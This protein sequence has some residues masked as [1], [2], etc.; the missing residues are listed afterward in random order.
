MYILSIHNGHN[1]TAA[2]AKDGQIIACVS[3]ERVVNQ[4]NFLGFPAK[5]IAKVLAMAG[6]TAQELDLVC[7]PSRYGAP[8]HSSSGTKKDLGVALF[9]WLYQPINVVR[10]VWGQL[11]YLIPSFS[12]IG[13]FFYH[14]LAKTVGVYT[15]YRERMFVA[16][17]LG[18]APDKIINF[19]HHQ[20]HA[21][22]AYLASPYNREKALVF[23]LD[24]E[25]DLLCAT[26]SIADKGQLTRIAATFRE[27]SFGWVFYYLT[28]YLG[29]KPMEHEYKVMGLA[30][31]AKEKDVEPLY[32][33]IEQ[34]ITLDQKNPLEFCSLFNTQDTYRYLKKEME[35]YRFDNIAA[36]F[37]KLL[38]E[39]LCEWVSFGIRKTGIDTV[40]VSGGVFMN[41]KANQRVAALPG[42][43]RFYVLPTCGD[44]SLPI[45]ACLTGYQLACS[46]ASQSCDIEPIKDIYWGP[47]WTSK[48]IAAFL[49][50]GNYARKYSVTRLDNMEERVAQLLAEGKVVGRMAGRMEW[51]A[52]ALGNRS[53]LADPSNSDVVMILNEQMK[54]RDFWMPFAPSI[55]QER[56]NDYLENPKH[57]TSPYMMMTFDATPLGKTKLKAA[58]HPYDGT[59][60]PQILEESWDPSYYHVI[61]EFERKTGIGA[62]LNTSFNLHGYPIVY[63]PEE[64]MFVFEHSGLS[65]LAL[66]NYLIEKR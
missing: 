8:I 57:L 13:R 2:L 60:R 43:K 36:A 24:G 32:R 11:V 51:G 15:T 62:V 25:G 14:L 12:F 20:M 65:Y 7:L 27:H 21:A 54:D 1:A 4:K 23:T 29:M 59:L 18:I 49:E 58:L 16:D 5:S 39:R 66:E 64:A 41:V 48:Q 42:V 30:P 10:W 9:V 61:K 22:A 52:R 46:K 28:K 26:V 63:G 45:G 47:A 17:Y 35:G 19:E 37:Q 53:L 3:E 50:A 40:I 55:L 6:I 38:E 31:Y 56:A 44:E 34:L 33:K